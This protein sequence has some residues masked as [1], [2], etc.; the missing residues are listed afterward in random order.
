MSSLKE[1]KLQILT[2]VIDGVARFERA[3]TIPILNSA[4]KDNGYNKAA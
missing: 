1:A 3:A 4:L 2:N